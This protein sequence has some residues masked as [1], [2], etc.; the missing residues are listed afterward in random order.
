M[1]R[2]Q[3][4]TDDPVRGRARRNSAQ[5]TVQR[6]L[7]FNA[8]LNELIRMSEPN[9]RL[10]LNLKENRKRLSCRT[11]SGKDL[12]PNLSVKGDQSGRPTVLFALIDLI[13]EIRRL[14][15]GAS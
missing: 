12:C 11:D 14:G 1:K 7:A 10:G 8:H 13:W 15:S 6:L 2:K 4:R 5:P 9:P 3:I